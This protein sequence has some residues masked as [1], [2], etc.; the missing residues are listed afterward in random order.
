MPPVYK[1]MIAGERTKAGTEEVLAAYDL[2]PIA[3]IAFRWLFKSLLFDQLGQHRHLS[4]I[5]WPAT[6]LL[7]D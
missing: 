2:S 6:S 3:E 5:T 4:R 7:P 1:S